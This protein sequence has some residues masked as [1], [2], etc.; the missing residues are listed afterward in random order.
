MQ[1]LYLNFI[2][3]LLMVVATG[4]T[5]MAITLAIGA[6]VML[7]VR[8]PFVPTPQRRVEKIIDEL[9]LATGKTFYDLGCGDGRFLI[10]AA[11]RGA[12]AIGLE[13]S[14][15]AFFRCKLNIWSTASSAQVRYK[16]FYS[17]SVADA[18]V[19]FCFL[20]DI[21]MPKIERKLLQELKPGALVASYGFSMPHWQPERV[22]TFDNNPGT[23]KLYVYRKT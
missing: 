19:V 20:L 21:V 5:L 2:T 4:L 23:S 3:L 12:R 22:V 11:K 16:N 18:D 7:L 8:V 6:A 10:A 15:T 14:P 17:V 13:L 1:Q 9:G